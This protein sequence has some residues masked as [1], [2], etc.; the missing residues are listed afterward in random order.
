M[1]VDLLGNALLCLV[2]F[3][4]NDGDKEHR[5]TVKIDVPIGDGGV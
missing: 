2:L 5:L 3:A 4:K 1:F